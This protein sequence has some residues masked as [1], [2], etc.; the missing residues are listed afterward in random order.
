MLSLLMKFGLLLK[1]EFVDE[2]LGLFLSTPLS[3]F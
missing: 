3:S 1:I 2:V